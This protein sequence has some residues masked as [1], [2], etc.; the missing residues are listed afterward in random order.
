VS[1]YTLFIATA[2]LAVVIPGPDFLLVFQTSVKH[3]RR[4]GVMS[5]VGIASG[6][7]VHGFA[8]T[9]GLSALLLKS[10]QAFEIVKWA[11]AVYL[12]YLAV[13]LIRDLMN[14]KQEDQPVVTNGLSQDVSYRQF[15]L[16]GFLTNVLNVKAALYFVAIVPQFVVGTDY[17]ALQLAVLSVTQIVVALV[18]FSFLAI[19]VNR[20]GVF[21]KRRVVQKWLDG[22]T[23]AIFLG[24]AVKLATTH[25]AT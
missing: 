13:F 4:A 7:I 17:V 5:A 3:N 9:V 19:A 20:V 15:V 23:A 16:R 11:G 22:T 10:A 1:Q 14:G 12:V 24:L 21:L 8:A 18:W 25:R 2:V 6:L